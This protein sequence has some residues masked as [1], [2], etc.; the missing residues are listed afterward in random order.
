VSR[1]GEFPVPSRGAIASEFE[2]L[3]QAASLGLLGPEVDAQSVPRLELLPSPLRRF[4]D[5]EAPP[6]ACP[7][8]EGGR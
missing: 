8:R 6:G 1:V 3:R 7:D 4:A 5:E 2:A